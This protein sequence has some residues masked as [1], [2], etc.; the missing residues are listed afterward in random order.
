MADEH[1]ITLNVRS[2]FIVFHRVAEV[3]A[4]IGAWP[5]EPATAGGES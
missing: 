5:V 1:Q 2:F 4:I 3:R